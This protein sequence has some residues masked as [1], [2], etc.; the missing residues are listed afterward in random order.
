[1]KTAIECPHCENAQVEVAKD[2]W[3]IFGFLLFARYGSKTEVGCQ[4]CVQRKGILNFILVLLF[5]WWCFPWGLGTPLALLQNLFALLTNNDRKLEGVLEN[6]GVRAEDV[7]VGSDGWTAEQRTL[8]NGIISILTEA[9][10][11]DG[12]LDDR[13]VDTAVELVSNMFD[14]AVSESKARQM[15]QD[16]ESAPLDVSSF[17]AEL[18][19]ILFHSAMRIVAADEKVEEGEA[20]FLH[21]LGARLE[22]PGEIVEQLL[23]T[24]KDLQGGEELV[25]SDPVLN[26]AYQILGLPVGSS[27]AEA[28]RNY[29]KLCVQYH[30]DRHTNDK[31]RQQMANDCMAWLN[32]S[33]QIA[34]KGRA[35]GNPPGE[36]PPSALMA[37]A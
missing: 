26:M 21:D 36:A 9:V 37:S 24:L 12:E 17:N 8:F 13:E 6:I 4:P 34:L 27:A 28:K 31:T 7:Q 2:Y 3:F 35:A 25:Q 11:S 20:Q 30:P 16:K 10:W 22:L 19:L 18:R 5:G 14:G 23:E 32:W 33:Y 15:I 1:M 29:R